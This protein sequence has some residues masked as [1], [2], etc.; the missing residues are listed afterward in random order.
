[1]KTVLEE[2]KLLVIESLI[3]KLSHKNS[4]DIEVSLNAHSVLI[5]MIDTDKTF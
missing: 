5:E 1:M 4:D 3:H 2:K